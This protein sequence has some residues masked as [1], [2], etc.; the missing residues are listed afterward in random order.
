MATP[1]RNTKVVTYNALAPTGN[2]LASK[3]A[4]PS[5]SPSPSPNIALLQAQLA[6][7]QAQLAQ[8]QAQMQAQTTAAYVA[9]APYGMLQPATP[10]TPTVPT[11]NKLASKPASPGRVYRNAVPVG[12]ITLQA[13]W[14]NL[15][16]HN[17]ITKGRF[18][19]L[20]GGDAGGNVPAHVSLTPV[21]VGATRYLPGWYATNQ[22]HNALRTGNYASAPQSLPA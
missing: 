13:V 1:K 11:G 16:A 7:A 6:Q 21:Y 10:A 15:R 20:F 19:K 22:G 12:Y 3:P 2:K 14:Q 8:A 4:S 9:V 18:V 17:V 5:P